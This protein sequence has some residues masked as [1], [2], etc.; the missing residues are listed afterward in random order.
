MSPRHRL[1]LAF[2]LTGTTAAGLAVLVSNMD[3]LPLANNTQTAQVVASQ[4]AEYGAA[5]Y[6]ASA[7]GE[8]SVVV[9][10]SSDTAPD[11]FASNDWSVSDN[12]SPAGN[13]LQLTISSL[14]DDGGAV[15]TDLEYRRDTGGGFGGWVSLNTTETGD[16]TVTVPAQ[17][18]TSFQLR[19]INSVGAGAASDS[20]T[21]TPT[22]SGGNSSG[23]Q[24]PGVG[25]TTTL[26]GNVSDIDNNGIADDREARIAHLVNKKR[27]DRDRYNSLLMANPAALIKRFWNRLESE[28]ALDPDY[29]YPIGLFEFE[30]EIT[31]PGA[32]ENIELILDE[33]YDTSEWTLRKYIRGAYQTIDTV[34]YGT[35]E[36][37]GE[38]V[39]TITYPVTDGGL[40]DS[41][42]LANGVI[43][44]PAGPGVPVAP[45]GTSDQET[46]TATETDDEVSES[47]ATRVRQRQGLPIDQ[48]TG[49]QIPTSD[50]LPQTNISFIQPQFNQFADVQRLERFL[51]EFAGE[52]LIVD[53]VYGAADNAAVM[54]FQ[55]KYARAV[56][57]IWDLDTATG[58]VGITT[59]FK[60]RNIVSG[61][62]AECPVFT[63]FNG[64]INGVKVSPEVGRTQEYLQELELY[65]GPITN[66]WDGA[67]NQAL[68]DFQETFREVMLDPWNIEQG[69][70]YKY[71]TTNKFL[72]Y[73]AG[74]DTGSVYLEGVG[75]YEGI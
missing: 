45:A 20:K 5:T 10:P 12:P 47:L 73:L 67:T 16:Y 69:T 26:R 13:R 3:V 41:D 53:G 46:D 39:T 42:G 63:E 68:I 25:A 35:R 18:E 22:R 43:I 14:P 37:D 56:L 34:T 49:G 21:V 8:G 65:D 58:Y 32:T 30:V 48:A 59:R 72:N 29:D 36:V 4:D 9:P 64:G 66:T 31:T 44:D 15:I 33:T 2:A 75:I 17:T 19:A 27:L 51:N 6:G 28:Y 24:V 1:A 40:L 61:A 23:N 7:Y 70:G 57:D 50:L 71:K 55:E 62:T 52:D 60:I 54:R 74:C 11:A 38:T